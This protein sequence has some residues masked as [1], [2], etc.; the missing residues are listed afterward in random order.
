MTTMTVI[1]MLRDS[2][3]AQLEWSTFLKPVGQAQVCVLLLGRHR[4]LQPPLLAPQRFLPPAG[5]TRDARGSVHEAFCGP[6]HRNPTVI[7][8]SSFEGAGLRQ[9]ASCSV[10]SCIC[11]ID[12]ALHDSSNLTHRKTKRTGAPLVP[13]RQPRGML[14]SDCDSIQRDKQTPPLATSP[15]RRVSREHRKSLLPRR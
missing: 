14:V 15:A 6:F 3:L 7:G 8:Q 10:F 1:Q 9:G 12:A 11:S 5:E 13:P 4:W 2:P